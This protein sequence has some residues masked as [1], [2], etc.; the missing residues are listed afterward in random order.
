M[1]R[2]LLV[3]F[4]LVLSTVTV[5]AQTTTVPPLI[6]YQGRLTD[7]DGK[8]LNGTKKL[9]FN[10]Y[11]AAIGGSLI[12]GPQI[13]DNPRVPLLDGYFN[14]ILGTTD[15]TG[16]LILTAFASQD[17]YLGIKVDGDTEI[18]PRQQILSSPYAVQ[19]EKARSADS[20]ANA[21]TADR[22]LAA[23]RAL[24]ADVADVLKDYDGISGPSHNTGIHVE[25][26]HGTLGSTETVWNFSRSFI[27]TP[28][29]VCSSSWHDG[30]SFVVDP[31][32][33]KICGG[34]S[35][36]YKSCICIGQ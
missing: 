32:S 34:G 3:A 13:F 20:A 18:T 24:T 9:E 14:V 1:I 15:S 6:N 16:R 23:D 29:C 27:D 25:Y 28:T 12:W 8:G 11:D 31:A 4:I 22:A 2:A 26:F 36:V 19:S 30:P 10:I 7:A 35:E 21:I 33:V 17:R 5:Y